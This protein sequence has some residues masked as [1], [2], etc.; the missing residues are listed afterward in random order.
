MRLPYKP[1]TA[2]ALRSA[3]APAQRAECARLP[4]TLTCQCLR[5]LR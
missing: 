1:R 4:P 5:P 3:S 2:L